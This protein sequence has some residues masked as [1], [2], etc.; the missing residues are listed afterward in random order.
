MQDSFTTVVSVDG[1]LFALYYALT[2]I[3][4]AMYYR[5]LATSGVWNFIHILV[6]PLAAAAYLAYIIVRSV[7]RLAAGAPPISSR[8][9][10]CWESAWRSCSTCGSLEGQT[11]SG[12][13][14]RPTARGRT[15]RGRR[16]RDSKA[17]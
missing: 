2:G 11:T 10:S 6:F 16:W 1:L 12:C 17:P 5:K 15:S 4:T 7:E 8:C 3:A 9:T 13:R 14:E